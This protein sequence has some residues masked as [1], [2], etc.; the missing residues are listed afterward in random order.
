MFTL[1]FV[2]KPPLSSCGF[3]CL[4]TWLKTWNEKMLKRNVCQNVSVR[5]AQ[6]RQRQQDFELWRHYDHLS[7][8]DP[9]NQDRLSLNSENAA[10]RN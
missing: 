8:Q 5:E 9:T 1:L 2:L 7:Y 10:L 3:V 6:P 4:G